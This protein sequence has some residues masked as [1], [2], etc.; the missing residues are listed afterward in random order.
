MRRTSK[1]RPQGPQGP[2]GDRLYRRSRKKK[3]NYVPIVLGS[4]AVLGLGGLYLTRSKTESPPSTQSPFQ[5]PFQSLYQSQSSFQ[6]PF[7]SSFKQAPNV[8]YGYMD[9]IIYMLAQQPSIYE[10]IETYNPE[11]LETDKNELRQIFDGD[12]DNTAALKLQILG[13]SYHKNFDLVDYH[14]S[15]NN[16]KLFLNEFIKNY[17]LGDLFAFRYKGPSKRLSDCPLFCS[18]CRKSI[19]RINKDVR[20]GF[21]TRELGYE[22][23]LFNMLYM[24]EYGKLCKFDFSEYVIEPPKF[25]ISLYHDNGEDDIIDYTD[26]MKN[27][28][29]P[30][31][32]NMTVDITKN[33]YIKYDLISYIT[34]NSYFG[35][36]YFILH[37]KQTN[38]SWK[39]MFHTTLQDVD[40]Y[41]TE[42]IVPFYKLSLKQPH[43]TKHLNNLLL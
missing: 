9:V 40:S 19:D 39:T 2:Q 24:C 6:S 16:V 5:S 20:H 8:E 26:F 42:F 22:N 29:N 31:Y 13:E 37:V 32:I 14:V 4:L 34:C 35:K 12:A 41:K 25:I 36:S 43:G 18:V 7:R 30:L 27:K 11:M 28:N 10:A 38:G 17:R 21:S 1:N 23:G 3:I 33:K 15:F